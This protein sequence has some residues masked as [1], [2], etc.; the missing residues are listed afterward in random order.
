MRRFKAAGGLLEQAKTQAPGQGHP[1]KESAHGGGFFPATSHVWSSF[2][3]RAA[4]KCAAQILQRFLAQIMSKVGDIFQI[5][6][7]LAAIETHRKLLHR[8]LRKLPENSGE[9]RGHLASAKGF[10]QYTCLPAAAAAP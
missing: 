1:A 7:Q 2:R 5:I 6:A 3:H 10:S 4:A 9:A 8:G